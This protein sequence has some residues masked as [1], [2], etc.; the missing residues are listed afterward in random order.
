MSTW[1]RGAFRQLPKEATVQQPRGLWSQ[2]C[3]F[4]PQ[5]DA[6]YNLLIPTGGLKHLHSLRP[7]SNPCSST[8]SQRVPHGSSPAFPRR[9]SLPESSAPIQSTLHP[10]LLSKPFP[11]TPAH[12]ERKKKVSPLQTNASSWASWPL[13]RQ[14]STLPSLSSI[15][16]ALPFI[17]YIYEPFKSP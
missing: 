9:S 2:P 11:L 17:F 14:R 3:S 15:F 16:L 7:A 12:E 5:L 13:L 6:V 8:D 10:P 1:E 4:Q